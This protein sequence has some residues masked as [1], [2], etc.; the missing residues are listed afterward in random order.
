MTFYEC[1]ALVAPY[2]NLVFVAI[3]VSLFI[4]LFRI[5]DKKVHIRPWKF[6]FFAI[7]V[8]IFV[9]VTSILRNAGVINLPHI[10]NAILETIIVTSFI[11]ML[12]IQKEHIKNEKIA[13]R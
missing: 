13:K 12:L 10:T 8:Y 3:V 1:L 9:Q 5:A 7:C 4:Y 6:L 11:Y 2:Y